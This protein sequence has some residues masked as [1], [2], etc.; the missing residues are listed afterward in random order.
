MNV[1]INGLQANNRSGTGVYVIELARRLPALAEPDNIVVAWP[2]GF[3]APV[4]GQGGA[5]KFLERPAEGFAGRI[6]YDQ[7]SIRRDLRRAKAHVVHYPANVGSVFPMRNMVVTIHDLTY[8]LEPGWYRYERARYYRAAVARSAR[9][10]AR[11]IAVSRATA[12]DIVRLLRVPEEKVAVVNQGAHERF[13]P[14]EPERREPVR[15]KYGLPNR[16]VLYYGTIEPRKNLVRLIQAWSRIAAELEHHLVI[17]G[18]TGWKTDAI[19]GEARR[20]PYATRIVFPGYIE[21]DD[22]PA[23]LSGADAIALPSLYEGFGNAISEGM[24]CGAPV[25]TSNVSSMPEVAGDAAMLV[26]PFDVDSIA[27]GLRRLL[28]DDA[29]RADLIDKG[30]A[31]AKTLS[32]TRTAEGALRVYREVAGE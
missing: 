21:D 20:S 26:D 14:V 28:T 12:S 32:W 30:M 22:L 10:A 29:L 24:A 8:F 2:R 1:L 15:R 18:R 7:I 23:V 6:W 5:A 4:S 17:A 27:H 31:R 11:I 13:R 16:Y 3:D 9:L 19:F 25:L